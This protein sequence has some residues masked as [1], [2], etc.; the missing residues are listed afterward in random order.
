MGDLKKLNLSDLDL[1]MQVGEINEEFINVS[2]EGKGDYSGSA[3]SIAYSMM[4]LGQYWKGDTSTA[5]YT[6][7]E[8]GC[9]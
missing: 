5:K 9:C 4:T 6:Y 2:G 3:A 7:S 1:D 8:R